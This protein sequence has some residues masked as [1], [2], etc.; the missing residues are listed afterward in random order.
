MTL[1]TIDSVELETRLLAAF[2]SRGQ[3]P[4]EAARI[5][6][7][8][9]VEAERL[10]MAEFGVSLALGALE[11]DD[12]HWD[13]PVSKAEQGAA[14]VLDAAELFAPIVFAEA[15]LIASARAGAAG[16]G[17]VV[18]SGPGS[19]GRIAPYARVIADAGLVGLVTV[20]S[21]PLVAPHGG[22]AAAL[23]TNP[24]AAAIPSSGAPIVV[25][26]SSSLLTKG[27]W[28]QL[29]ERGEQVP[30]G[31]AIAADGQLTRDAERVGAFLPR[32]GAFGTAMG[33]I[34]E[35][36]TNG[37]SGSLG[38]ARDRR[39]A[40]VLA[41]QSLGLDAQLSAVGDDLRTRL[42]SAGGYV[43][44]SNAPEGPGQLPIDDELLRRLERIAPAAP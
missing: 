30:E 38:S 31:T 35:M 43:P 37:L 15:A 22:T 19:L 39:S 10:G 9:I 25:D 36:V 26:A 28:T 18:V 5:A 7:A 42:A 3:A 11:S 13:R 27:R 17:I 41:M 6:A 21:P 12:V 23:G 2:A 29:R 16:L 32:G 14:V 24:I 33:V 4:T 44:G 34:A 20:G 1:T 8:A 40:C